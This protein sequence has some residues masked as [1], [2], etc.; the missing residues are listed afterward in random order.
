[1][2]LF[3]RSGLVRDFAA[4]RF[5]GVRIADES[6]PAYGIVWPEPW[7]LPMVG[8]ATLG[9]LPNRWVDATSTEG[10]HTERSGLRR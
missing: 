8:Y 3:S 4:A 2:R 6:Y 10:S 5:A 9:R 1:M 7:S